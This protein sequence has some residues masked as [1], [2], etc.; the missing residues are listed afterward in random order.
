MKYYN[1]EGK[2]T[3]TIILNLR[4]SD[5]QQQKSAKAAYQYD[6]Y[7]AQSFTEKREREAYR[8]NNGSPP[9]LHG[10]SKKMQGHH[11]YN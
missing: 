7:R 1:R 9:L 6:D 4:K 2:E 5:P 11:G 8:K 3:L 10:S